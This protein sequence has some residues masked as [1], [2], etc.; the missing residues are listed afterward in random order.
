[1][2]DRFL[3]VWFDFASPYSDPAAMR[4]GALAAEAQVKMPHVKARFRP[5]LLG[6]IFGALDHLHICNTGGVRCAGCYGRSGSGGVRPQATHS[7]H[8]P[9]SAP[10]VIV[11]L[12]LPHLPC[13]K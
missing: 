10:P 13:L 6:P 2:R 8:A 5:F 11:V 1:M 7:R 12:A 9:V 4:I 3:D